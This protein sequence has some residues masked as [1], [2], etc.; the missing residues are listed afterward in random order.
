MESSPHYIAMSE[1]IVN[2]TAMVKG[3]TKEQAQTKTKISKTKAA[4]AAARTD[5][6]EGASGVEPWVTEA[7]LADDLKETHKWWHTEKKKVGDPI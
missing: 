1:Q 6:T 4:L 5:Y 7:I 3:L 2:L